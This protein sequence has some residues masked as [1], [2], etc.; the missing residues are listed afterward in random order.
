MKTRFREHSDRVLVAHTPVHADIDTVHRNMIAL[1]DGGISTFGNLN[2]EILRNHLE[3]QGRVL[4]RTDLCLPD[5][6]SIG[7]QMPDTSYLNRGTNAI[8]IAMYYNFI[9]FKEMSKEGRLFTKDKEVFDE[10]G[11]I[12]VIEVYLQKNLER[13]LLTHGLNYFGTPKTLTECMRVLE[14]WDLGVTPRLKSYCAYADFIQEWCKNNYPHY[15][16]SE[17]RLGREISEDIFKHT[18][19]NHVRECIKFFWQN[20]L[21]KKPKKISPG[22]VEIDILGKTFNDIRRPDFVL[23]GQDFL[24][25]EDSE[26]KITFR[27]FQ[28]GKVITVNHRK[29]EN[30]KSLKTAELISEAF[31]A[32]QVVVFKNPDSL[33][34]FSM[35]KLDEIK[36]GVSREVAL[37]ADVLCELAL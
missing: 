36:S 32:S 20:F 34:S 9:T 15:K 26:S 1:S 35:C 31:P 22:D 10:L 37:V 12:G 29:S 3:Q 17:F 11:R 14:G 21:L 7:L 19:T 6:V 24:T 16:S 25:E 4:E 13:D 5:D 28:S 33:P 8:S 27:G 23:V 18:G 30:D 2:T